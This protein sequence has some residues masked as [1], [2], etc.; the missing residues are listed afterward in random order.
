MTDPTGPH[1]RCQHCRRVLPEQH[2]VGRPR[3]FCSG[4]CR[5]R[6]WVYR[7]RAVELK[8]SDDELIVMRDQLD[9]LYDELYVLA[10]AVQD[11]KRDGSAETD[12][13]ATQARDALRWI[14]EAAGPL[15]DPDRLSPIRP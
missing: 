12:A 15:V 8:L 9:A 10:C 7:Q 3:R 6:E 13:T 4:A 2:G 14:I 5:Q 11:V 1:K